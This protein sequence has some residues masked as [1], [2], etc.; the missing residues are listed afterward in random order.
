MGYYHGGLPQQARRVVESAF[1]EGEIRLLF[2]TT[3]FGEG[4]H[5]PDIRN[6]VLYHPCFSVEAFNQLA[7]RCARDGEP[8]EHPPH[9]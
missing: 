3:A 7:G 9:V 1:K 2:A 4:V 5:I 6:V 8:G